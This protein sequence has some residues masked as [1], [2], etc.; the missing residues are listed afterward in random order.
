MA[1]SS[2]STSTP[3]ICEYLINT[4]PLFPSANRTSELLRTPQ[5][6]LA[7]S[8]LPPTTQSSVLKFYHLKDA[9]LSLLSHL[10]KRY[11][12][13]SL[14][15]IPWSQAEPRKDEKTGKP[16][17]SGGNGR[18]IAFNVSHQAGIVA[19]AAV[20]GYGHD[21]DDDDDGVQVG[22]DVVSTSERSIRDRQLISQS[23]G[24]G[25][26]GGVEK[27]FHKFV[28]I[29]SEVFGR[30]ETDFLAN[31][32]LVTRQLDQKTELD[33]TD[34]RLRGFYSL[35]CLREAYVKMTGEALLAPW[36]GDLEFRGWMAPCPSGE[37]GFEAPPP[38]EESSTQGSG[39][40]KGNNEDGIL[41]NP[42]IWLY[43]KKTDDTN[44]VLKSLGTSIM[45]STAVRTPERKEDALGW[46]LGRY[47]MLDLETILQHAKENA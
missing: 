29:H 5:A 21:D 37:R 6:K 23:G 17:F 47:R 26:S 15:Q 42:E 31:V 30:G 32:P 22:I 3:T 41:R 33:E 9:K 34:K 44:I 45:V 20:V 38:L 7:L 24:G 36:L 13:S 35:W 39:Q 27:G 19:G 10:L 25:S 14:L 8:L 2:P 46:D 11:L 12:I 16:I 1:P 4:H 43:R 40:E 28:S 18:S